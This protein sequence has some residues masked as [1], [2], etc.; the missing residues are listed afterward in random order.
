M[1]SKP[2]DKSVPLQYIAVI[3]GVSAIMGFFLLL[4]SD[5]RSDRPSGL[6]ILGNTNPIVASEQSE[7]CSDGLDNDGDGEIDCGGDCPYDCDTFFVDKGGVGG[8]ACSGSGTGRISQPWCTIDKAS[9]T[10]TAGQTVLVRAGVYAEPIIA[11]NSGTSSAYITYK[12]F[13][14]ESVIINPTADLPSGTVINGIPDDG[15]QS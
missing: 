14:E 2:A 1:A 7:L 13:G 9:N 4:G 11:R 5:I 10:L 12:N 3:V 8:F 15:R 6:P